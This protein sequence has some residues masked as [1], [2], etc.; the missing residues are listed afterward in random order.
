[1]D[2][3]HLVTRPGDLVT[4]AHDVMLVGLAQGRVIARE[5]LAGACLSITVDEDCPM[6][7]TKDYRVVVRRAGTANPELSRLVNTNEGD[8]RKLVFRT[9]VE[10]GDGLP[11]VGDLFA[12]GEAGR[13][14]EPWIVNG[15][16]PDENLE[17][18]LTLVP[19][20]PAVHT[21]DQKEIPDY[22]PKITIPIEMRRPTPPRIIDVQAGDAALERLP[23]GNLR[24]RIVAQVR[25]RE[26]FGEPPI[27]RLE[28]QARQSSARRW[29]DEGVTVEG[30]SRVVVREVR[31]GD[32]FDLRVRVISDF[33]RAS[34]WVETTGIE[35]VGATERPSKV[36]G[37][38][39]EIIGATATLYW[40]APTDLD[41]SHYLV[42][43][44]A[45][46]SGAQWAASVHVARVP[47]TS[48][49]VEVPLKVGTYLIKAVDNRGR[50]SVVA[51]AVS[52]SIA[53]VRNLNFVLDLDADPDFDGEL[54]NTIVDG[55]L[56]GLRLVQV[57]AELI[58]A[59]AQA[60]VQIEVQSGV[61]LVVQAIPAVVEET[62]TWD[63][64]DLI[65]LGAVFTARVTAELVIN[66]VVL[67]D[68]VFEWVDVFAI[69]DVFGGVE[70]GVM[71]R[72]YLSTTDDDPDGDPT[73]GDWRLLQVGDYTAR[74]F[75]FRL[76]L[77]SVT[78][79]ATPV[80][81]DARFVVDMADRVYSRK[82]TVPAI[83]T[84]VDFDPPFYVVPDVGLTIQGG[85]AGDRPSY[86]V[87]EDGMTIQVLNSGGSGVQRVVEIFARAYGE[88]EE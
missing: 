4:V 28:A 40:Q 32:R 52:T 25:V 27:A 73:W 2:M 83:G 18:T 67:G 74:A 29:D 5:M 66:A 64:D 77:G 22:R 6:E 42:R 20:A 78:P 47:A 62:G 80:V 26:G 21:A 51:S 69:E 79:G 59:E 60:G 23:N 68:D 70:D 65:D 54:D 45:E 37:T 87:D 13:V 86:T 19:H 53:R 8:R 36:G 81:L 56:G 39:I 24:P 16:D 9:P 50:T 7:S 3:E 17:A 34:R 58:I 14:T 46:V 82:V 44:S 33:G 57:P 85:A 48:T 30:F 61:P 55:D 10:S 31:A 12:F 1:M 63:S 71:V 15:I 38:N 88:R 75:R 41:V 76:E 84:T 11:A 43:H 49:S 35:I 72:A